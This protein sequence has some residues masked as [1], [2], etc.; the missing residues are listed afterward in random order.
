MAARARGFVVGAA[1]SAHTV[2][3]F[4]DP[5]CPHCGHLWEASQPL[6]TQ[7]RFV[8]VPVA[9]LG[10]TSAAQGATL[11]AAPK[12]ELAMAEHEKS[13]LAGQGGITASP[14]LTAAVQDALVSNTQLFAEFDLESVPTVVAKH[15]RTGQTVVKSGA[16]TPL[17]LAE[18]LGVNLPQ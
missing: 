18:F 5:Q 7:V 4:F 14:S 9:I 12:P 10:S 6:L 13:L 2:Y 11:L 1:M 8:W 17:A 15:G 3:V 16:L